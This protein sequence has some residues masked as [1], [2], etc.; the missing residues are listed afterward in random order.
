VLAIPPKRAN[1]RT[2][3]FLTPDEA[4]ALLAD[5]NSAP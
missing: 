4:Q 2:I 3:T 1:A 5:G